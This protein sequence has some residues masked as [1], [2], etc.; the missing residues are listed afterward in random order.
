MGC[1]TQ[2]LHP[3]RS[4]AE[5]QDLG[6][7]SQHPDMKW[8]LLYLGI[9]Q[10]WAPSWCKCL[11]FLE[12]TDHRHANACFH[13]I[14][15]K[16]DSSILLSNGSIQQVEPVIWSSVLLNISSEVPKCQDYIFFESIIIQWNFN[17]WWNR[18][19]FIVSLSVNKQTKEAWGILCSAACIFMLL[20]FIFLP[21]YPPVFYWFYNIKHTGQ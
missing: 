16:C 6:P 8:C 20:F 3:H 19:K 11:C 13:Y 5:D 14:Q 1:N 17:L 21:F 9:Y 12:V 4:A 18:E 10:G 7:T 15:D 2:L